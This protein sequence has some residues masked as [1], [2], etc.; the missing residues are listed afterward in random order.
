MKIDIS[1]YRSYKDQLVKT[2]DSNG[3]YALQELC[4]IS[5]LPLI[6]AMIFVLEEHP[7]D[8]ELQKVRDRVIDFYGYT[9]I[10]E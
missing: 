9:E 10:I 6:A 7:D 8:K 4:V 3:L 1:S 2:Y 5:G